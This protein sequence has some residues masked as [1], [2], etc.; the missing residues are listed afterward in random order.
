[1]DD[2]PTVDVCALTERPTRQGGNNWW[3]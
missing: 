1:M 3:P 2:W